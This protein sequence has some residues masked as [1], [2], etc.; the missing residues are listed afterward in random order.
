VN[1]FQQWNAATQAAFQEDVRIILK[2]WSGKATIT[3]MHKELTHA[4]WSVS[5]CK[6]K[7]RISTK[8][9]DLEDTLKGAGFVV[10][11][12]AAAT[13]GCTRATYIT[14]QPRLKLHIEYSG[15]QW[16]AAILDKKDDVCLWAASHD[17]KEHL[18][19]VAEAELKRLNEEK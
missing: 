19:V 12:V 14:E 9:G 16:V 11:K 1:L 13:H 5:K 2:G 17:D 10:E 15:V 3:D 6:Q 4:R 18:Q 7:W 8:W